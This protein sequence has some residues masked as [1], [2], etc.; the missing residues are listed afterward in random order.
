M[1]TQKRAM[2]KIAQ[3]QKEE[4]SSERIKLGKVDDINELLE[5]GEQRLKDARNEIEL[6]RTQLS[7]GLIIVDQNVPAQAE[8]AL[9]IAEDLGADSIVQ[10]LKS[11]IDKAN[12]LTE[13]F[14]PLYKS[15][16]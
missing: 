3:I 6:L 1:N 13:E 7:D 2:S 15:I 5:K 11:I 12:R 8:N 14:L 9:K 16:G 10:E 4:L